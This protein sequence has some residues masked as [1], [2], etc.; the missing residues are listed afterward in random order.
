M[1]AERD[2]S[3]CVTKDG[4]N[5]AA[6]E[7]IIAQKSYRDYKA[8]LEKHR[9]RYKKKPFEGYTLAPDTLEA[10]EIKHDYLAGNITE[11]EY[12]AYCLKENLI[13]R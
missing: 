13:E 12:K 11:E 9:K 1:K 2:Y 10:I 3:K 4:R 7:K 5:Y 8:A 6:I